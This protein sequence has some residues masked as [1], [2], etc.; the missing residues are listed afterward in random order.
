MTIPSRSSRVAGR[1]AVRVLLADEPSQLLVKIAEPIGVAVVGGLIFSTTFTLLVIP[2][3]HVFV[4]KLGE[5][6]GLNT[7]PPL[8]EL[9]QPPGAE[10]VVA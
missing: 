9:E 8:I 1:R 3:V 7:V 4:V 10:T 2:A 6:I 5:T